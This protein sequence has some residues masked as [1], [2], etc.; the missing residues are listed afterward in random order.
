MINLKIRTEYSF[1]T[2]YGRI[3]TIINNCK[4]KHL[5]ITD[6][7][8]FG[9]VRFY[10]ACKKAGINPILGLTINV[11][12]DIE[13]MEKQ[14][15][16]EVILL[17]KNNEGLKEIYRINTFANEH[18]YYVPR[19]DYTHIKE[20][21]DNVFII[22]PSDQVPI[23]IRIR[24]N[25]YIS[26]DIALPKSE[27]QMIMK[28]SPEGT[29]IPIG[30]NYYPTIDDEETYQLFVKGF[31][32]KSTPMH[33]IDEAE[34]R[35][36]IPNFPDWAFK[37][38]Y[39]IAQQCKVILP[40]GGLPVFKTDKTIMEIC[41]EGA[42]KRSLL[43]KKAIENGVKKIPETYVLKP[44][45]MER[46][47]TEIKLIQ[48]K[49]YEDYFYIISDLVVYAKEHMLV[50]P[51]RGS[52]AG[53]LVCYLMGITD[54]DPILHGLIFERFIDINR[55]DLPDIDIDFQDDK[56]YMVFDYLKEK[57]G[58]KNV[59]T[60]GT[61]LTM[62]S[63]S[64]LNRVAEGLGVPLFE[65]EDLKNAI[66]KRSAGDER[67]GFGI[68]D[69]FD[70]L[71]IGQKVIKKYPGMAHAGFM[72]GHASH[73]GKH[74]AGIVVSENPIDDYCSKTRD[75]VCQIDKKDAEKINMLKIDALG[76]RTLSII[77][78]C[79]DMI[80]KDRDWLLNYPL[81]D[82]KAW[83]ILNEK[84]FSGI[85][86]FEG[87]ALQS[88]TGQMTVENF[89]DIVCITSLARPGPLNSGS[90]S[91]FIKSRIGETEPTYIHELMK[92]DTEETL[93]CII[94]QE[95][96][97][98]IAR[99]IGNLNWAD[100]S[101][102]RKAISKSLGEE[103]I[104]KFWEKFEK[105]AIKN[106]LKSKK[107]K[108]I[109]NNICT[110]GSYGF[111]KSHAVS[112]G[113]ISYWCLIL[114]AY[115][116]LEFYCACLRHSA[117]D[118]QSIKLLREFSNDGGKFIPF[119]QK[120]SDI[121]WTIQHTAKKSFLVGGFTNL[122]GVGEKKA[123]TLIAK[124]ENDDKLTPK[125]AEMM[126]DPKTPFDHIFEAKE[127]FNDVYENPLKYK[128]K[129]GKVS[130]I[131]ELFAKGKGDYVFIAKLKIKNLRDS[132][133][134]NNIQRRGGKRITGPTQY[135]SCTLE[136][137]TGQIKANVGRFD[138][139]EF[140][141]PIFEN[142]KEDEWLMWKGIIKADFIFFNIL[143]WRLME[144]VISTQ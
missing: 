81:D 37:N 36:L 73:H 17:A 120:S 32:S 129:G 103:Y 67:A 132:N 40:Q 15:M 68:S 144:D 127:K 113:L 13:L 95:Q 2:A 116:S 139:E 31:Q 60:I 125:Q 86:Q 115:H 98:N 50:G 6:P 107:A 92:P 19:I 94:F 20:L 141:K 63:K 47:K 97:M 43:C 18:F 5:A 65:I 124:L 111:N 136:D 49:E 61:V 46:L 7:N 44:E 118:D 89:N 76:L 82:E 57:Y 41:M 133:D 30:D 88:L 28:M 99:N 8:T 123:E 29:F 140:G 3:Q 24:K 14:P 114:K 119:A 23:S 75:D 69:T 42:K 16:D 70:N 87:F 11:V 51:S 142:I 106:G 35:G 143:K 1:G 102:L 74:A 27:Q 45:Y 130:R 104:N 110:Y 12:E 66:E 108:E 72:E 4:E 134:A 79:L 80:G 117:G 59:G 96:V 26:I 55:D 62:Q 90:A 105:G 83:E 84:K 39:K 54:V 48:E 100:V 85:F 58:E 93:G 56:R 10:D 126:A 91:Q 128:V 77:Q 109:W 137:D 9:H 112:Y 101:D 38:T 121:N 25:V 122:I 53:S 138:Y 135:L 34:V 78:D 52:S 64:A 21:T 131:E 33:I 71:D 22:V